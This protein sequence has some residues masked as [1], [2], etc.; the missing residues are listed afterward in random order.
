MR[1]KL[2]KNDVEVI[3]IEKKNDHYEVFARAWE[4]DKQIGFG[5]DG[6]IDVERFRFFT[7]KNWT[8]EKLL[9]ELSESISVCGKI[10]GSKKI[11]KDKRG[12]TVSTF[13]PDADAED[14][15]CSRNG[16]TE[17]W[18]TIIA[19]AGTLSNDSGDNEYVC[20]MLYNGSNWIYLRR[21]IFMFDTSSIP[22]TDE[23]SAGTFSIY[24]TTNDDEHSQSISLVLSNPASDT[25]LVAADFGTFTMTKQA[26]DVAQSSISTSQY[27][28]WTLNATGRGNV[29][30]TGLTKFGLVFSGDADSSEPPGV[31]NSSAIICDMNEKAGTGTDPKLVITH[32]AAPSG[33]A[34]IKTFNDI[35]KAS[36]KTINDV[37]LGSVKT[38]NDIA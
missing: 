28:D 23:V 2:K 17:S 29:N 18:A 35:A 26:A 12:S 27:N 32:A 5:K 4:Q 22:D 10:V 6:S 33:P 14:G 13:Y 25:A 24:V 34:N 37:A 30:K 20:Y 3:S 36:V 19:G 7:K 16:V 8:D 21:G 11:V 9:S 15:H 1:N 38:W 31:A